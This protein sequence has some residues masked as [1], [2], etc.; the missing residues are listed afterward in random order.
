MFSLGRIDAKKL[1]VNGTLRAGG[2]MRN[3]IGRVFAI[4]LALVALPAFGQETD[5]RGAWQA[6]TYVLKNG[7]THHVEGLMLFTEAE[8]AVVYFVKDDEGRPQRGA[9]EGG[10]YTLDGDRLVLTRDYLV[11]A[12]NAIG[13]LP[14]IPL[15]FD[16]PGVKEPVVEECRLERS[17]NRITIEFP[18]GNR[19]GFR[20]AGR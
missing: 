2:L 3:R 12:S 7:S 20:R 8:W 6:D 5:I 17:S 9:G 14:E 16:V 10:P 1:A 4:A 19:M 11:I 15:R 13:S 18:S